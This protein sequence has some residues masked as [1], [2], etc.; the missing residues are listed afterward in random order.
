MQELPVAFNT[1]PI[2]NNNIYFLVSILSQNWKK[3]LQI[4][5]NQVFNSMDEYDAGCFQLQK[6]LI[7]SRHARFIHTFVP[8]AEL[9]HGH[10]AIGSPDGVTTVLLCSHA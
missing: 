2:V 5:Y 6:Y 8:Q 9:K 3:Y 4:I 10:K 7:G 1:L